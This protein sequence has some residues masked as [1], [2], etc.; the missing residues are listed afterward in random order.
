MSRKGTGMNAHQNRNLYI[1]LYTEGL[2]HF[3]TMALLR[4]SDEY[5]F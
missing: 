4:Y 2:V 5:A 1:P 3:Y